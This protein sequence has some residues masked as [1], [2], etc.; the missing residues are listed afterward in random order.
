MERAIAQTAC[1]DCG[2]ERNVTEPRCLNMT[3]PSH[4]AP[5]PT[6]EFVGAGGYEMRQ[7]LEVEA[8]L[9]GALAGPES[10]CEHIRNALQL[11]SP[12]EPPRT[13]YEW[14]QCAEIARARLRRALEQLEAR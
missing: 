2:S 1:P 9:P 5:A 13:L 11:L 7:P 8:G 3:C 4:L 6:A 10:A 14:R 12:E